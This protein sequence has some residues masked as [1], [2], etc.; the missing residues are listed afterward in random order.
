MS[1]TS[2]VAI[3]F[4]IWWTTLFAVL[5]WRIRSAHESGATVEEGHDAGAPVVHGLK[6]KALVTTVIATAIFVPVYLYL[7]NGGLERLSGVMGTL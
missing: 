1:T 7:S 6:W 5:P 3:Y 4:I 2:S